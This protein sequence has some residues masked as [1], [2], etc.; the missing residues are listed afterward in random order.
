MSGWH[1]FRRSGELG[2]RWC[3]ILADGLSPDAPVEVGWSAEREDGRRRMVLGEVA[4]LP[5]LDGRPVHV[6]LPGAEI[7]GVFA[8]LPPGG[9]SAQRALPWLVEPFLLNDVDDNHMAWQRDPLRSQRH[10]VW[11]CSRRWRDQAARLL[12]NLGLP[13]VKL[14]PLHGL[15]A[16]HPGA[17][18]LQ[19]LGRHW[20]F[21]DDSGTGVLPSDPA[22]RHDAEVLQ[23]HDDPTAL[24]DW[25]VERLTAVGL[26]ALVSSG[27][28]A[29]EAPRA[30]D[31]AASW[32]AW[33]VLGALLLADGLHLR[34]Q[35]ERL[36]A[37]SERAARSAVPELEIRAGQHWRTALGRWQSGRSPQ[38]PAEPVEP[39][40]A[41]LGRLAQ[42][43]GGSDVTVRLVRLGYG[44]GKLTLAASMSALE[45][46][47]TLRNA[48]ERAGYAV[49]IRSAR[50]QSGRVIAELSLMLPS[51]SG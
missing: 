37:Q 50:G 45:D 49:E 43:A 16:T 3:V 8:T 7:L 10:R 48:L 21:G 46:A 40:A 17:L 28:A 11:I 23:A 30:A 18:R 47:S 38:A 12:T 32:G 2:R 34:Q 42:A 44:E 27:A 25:V 39:L 29:R 1:R 14:V 22:P 13:Q 6:V 36:A 24:F 26:P 5:C 15:L 20:C 35:S 33:A 19:R 4:Q 41:R 9:R 31:C 51:W